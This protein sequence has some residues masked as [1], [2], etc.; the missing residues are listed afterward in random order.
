MA[1]DPNKRG[2]SDRNR[3]NIYEEWE[4]R[5]WTRHFGCTEEQ[6]KEAVKVAG[7]MVRNVGDYLKQKGW[8]SR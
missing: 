4:V 7:V 8:S 3:I 5:D 1:D 2:T 6:L